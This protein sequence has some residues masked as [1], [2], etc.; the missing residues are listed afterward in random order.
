MQNEELLNTEEKQE[1]LGNIKS[2][3]GFILIQNK[4]EEMLM[5]THPWIPSFNKY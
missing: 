4:P 2:V 3:F 1:D 5:N